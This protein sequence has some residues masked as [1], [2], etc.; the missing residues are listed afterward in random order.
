VTGKRSNDGQPAGDDPI[1]SDNAD[2]TQIQVASFSGPLPHPSLLARYNDV[3]PGGADRIMAMA[4]RQSA[5]R[6]KLEA[7]VVLANPANQARGSVFA[8]I[9]CLVTILGGM[10]LIYGGRD[11]VGL[12]A[13]IASLAGLASVFFVS[14]REQRRERIEKAETLRSRKIQ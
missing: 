9:I 13:V 11:A 8:F 6:E 5:H 10:F 2:V 4:E 3:I 7:E 12:A 1:S 14:R